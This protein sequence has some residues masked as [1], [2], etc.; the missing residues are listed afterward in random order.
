MGI[1]GLEEGEN[2]FDFLPHRVNRNGQ[3]VTKGH[4]PCRSRTPIENVF[5][6][7]GWGTGGFKATPA[8]G[9]VFADLIAN[10]EPGPFARPFS[11]D[12]FT[13]GALIDEHGAAGVAH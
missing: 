3:N 9:W 6:N 13:S 11:L 2:C 10:G 12:R 1:R 4:C 7:C 8:S 5:L